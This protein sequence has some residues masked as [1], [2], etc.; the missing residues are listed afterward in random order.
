MA[1]EEEDRTLTNDQELSAEERTSDTDSKSANSEE[2]GSRFDNAKAFFRALNA[3]ADVQPDEFGI[4]VGAPPE[5]ER[6]GP[7]SNC[8]AL[9]EAR[10]AAEAKAADAENLYK[11]LA[12]DWE[13][14][15]KRTDREREEFQELGVLKG[16]KEILP[17]LDDLDRA[18][19]HFDENSD[20]RSMLESLTLIYNRFLKSLEQLGVKPIE[21]VGQAF[22]PRLH[23]PVQ[24]IETNDIPEGHVAAELRRGYSIKDKVIRPALV[25]V[26]VPQA[27]PT[28]AKAANDIAE[29]EPEEREAPEQVAEKVLE[30]VPEKAPGS[31]VE[32]GIEPAPQKAPEPT[33]LK[34]PEPAP[35]KAAEPATQSASPPPAQKT[36]EPPPAHDTPPPAAQ[37]AP[38]PP[39][40]RRVPE[41]APEPEIKVPAAEVSMEQ[42]EEWDDNISASPSP[43]KQSKDTETG[44]LE[45]V[46]PEGEEASETV[47]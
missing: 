9:E 33:P 6:S 45:V 19:S 46:R 18:Q 41:P 4:N 10:V 12:A 8:K 34:A 24:Q 1:R 29:V 28:H 47:V 31:V 43:P 11:R 35:E 40:T 2:R 27:E 36:P 5:A 44:D 3:G 26:A 30:P 42:P 14:Y 17:A 7:C 22:D 16:L 38:Q 23:E 20:S 21:V 32:K 13:N 39:P 15:R 25:N 37:N